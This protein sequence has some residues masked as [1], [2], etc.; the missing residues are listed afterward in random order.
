[1]IRLS[2]LTPLQAKA[3]RLADNQLALN[4]DWDLVLLQQELKALDE[5][6]FTLDVIGFDDAELAELEKATNEEDL[7]ELE[8]KG[9]LL[10]LIDVT[11]SEPRH[12]LERGDHYRL[13]GR[14]HLICNSVISGW[15]Q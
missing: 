12:Q 15:P 8:A 11:L 4:S 3:F 9:A 6:N 10:E 13:N 5:A 7:S 14:H 2:H 1:M